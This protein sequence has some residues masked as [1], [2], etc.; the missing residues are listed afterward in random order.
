MNQ[1]SCSNTGFSFRLLWSM[2]VRSSLEGFP[3]GS[4]CTLVEPSDSPCCLIHPS[5]S[6]LR[7]HQGATGELDW[8]TTR[9]SGKLGKILHPS[10][11]GRQDLHPPP[12]S[13][14]KPQNRKTMK[15]GR[16]N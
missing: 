7:L 4:L 1:E 9:M 11:L 5:P 3:D 10:S 14:L 13:H 16:N 12:S 8:V 6:L 2:C 15:A